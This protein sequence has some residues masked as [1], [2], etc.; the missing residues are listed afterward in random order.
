M[1]G[2]QVA[3]ADR[4]RGQGRAHPA[5]LGN[6]HGHVVDLVI[7]VAGSSH[8]SLRLRHSWRELA[9]RTHERQDGALAGQL[10]PFHRGHAIR[11][12]YQA[13]GLAFDVF[14]T[15]IFVVAALGASITQRRHLD[16]EGFRVARHRSP[17]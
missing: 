1:R 4:H 6:N 13:A 7:G 3:L 12:G 11:H 5:Q 8:Q 15:M 2:R 10:A 16:L 9:K 17:L 14:A